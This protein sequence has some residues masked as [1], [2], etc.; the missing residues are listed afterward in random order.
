MQA[1]LKLLIF[2]VLLTK[3]G[4]VEQFL[5]KGCERSPFC[6]YDQ[7]Q[8]YLGRG[9]YYKSGLLCCHDRT[10]QKNVPKCAPLKCE[11]CES[12]GTN[13]TSTMKTCPP[14][15]ST[16]AVALIEN[17]LVPPIEPKTNGMK[18][19]ACYTKTGT[20][21]HEMVACTGLQKFCFEVSSV[22]YAEEKKV[23]ALKRCE[24]LQICTVPSLQFS[25]GNGTTYRA[26]VACCLE[27]QCDKAVPELPPI[28]SKP[29]GKICPACLVEGGICGDETVACVGL[30]KFCFEVATVFI[31]DGKEQD[32]IIKGC[33]TQSVCSGLKTGNSPMLDVEVVK[34][35]K[36][37]PL[38]K[39]FRSIS[40]L[41]PPFS[42][43][44]LLKIF[45]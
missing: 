40:L 38:S 17:A 41:L 30:E 14:H 18:C 2:L 3:E 6:P 5:E 31:S 45:L 29:N 10:C 19:P 24:S 8:L 44:L 22:S 32:R 1:L 42:V 20:C 13:C 33:T 7:I 15:I 4:K 16:C 28:E 35:V 9:R 37:N 27:G 21:G 25:A 36:C 34:E 39:G 23:T 11:T 12:H 43:L 26:G